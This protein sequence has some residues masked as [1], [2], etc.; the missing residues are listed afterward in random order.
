NVGTLREGAKRVKP[1]RRRAIAH[2]WVGIDL[3]TQG[4]RVAIVAEDGAVLAMCDSAIRSA[5]LADRRH[6]QDPEAWKLAVSE[7]ARAGLMSVGSSAVAGLATCGTSGTFLV[8]DSHGRPPT[9]GVR[10]GAS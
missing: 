10:Y 4:C 3:G 7:A 2:V 1:T 6:E 8:A 9:R 5:P